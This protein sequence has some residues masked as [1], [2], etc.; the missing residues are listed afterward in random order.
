LLTG[1]VQIE[2]ET[3]DSATVRAALALPPGAPERPMT[4]GEL[5]AKLELCG[6]GD[7]AE[8]SWESAAEFLRS[9]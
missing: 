4:D 1:E 3:D 2:I 7:L 5:R 6:A 9:L 8:L